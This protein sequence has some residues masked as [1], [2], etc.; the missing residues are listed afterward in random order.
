MKKTLAILLALVMVLT[1]AA[2]QQAPEGTTW[3]HIEKDGEVIGLE[4]NFD[5]QTITAGGIIGGV[6]AEGSS[7]EILQPTSPKKGDVYHYTYEEDRITITYPNGASWWQSGGIGGWDGDY[8]T[9]RYIAGDTLAWH[10]DKA[11]RNSGKNWDEV[12]LIG[13]I[14]LLIIGFGI[15]DII[16]PEILFKMRYTLWVRDAEPTE[17]ALMMSRIGGVVAVVAAVIMFLVVAFG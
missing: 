7:G 6:I 12:V 5:E 14:C 9:Q 8:D 1:L 2:C 16:H 3:E 13:M 15:L 4:I 11:Y 17:F 10:L